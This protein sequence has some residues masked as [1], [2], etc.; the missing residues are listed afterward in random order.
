MRLVPLEAMASGATGG[1]PG[2]GWAEYGTRRK[3]L[4]VPARF[5]WR[6][7]ADALA[8]IIIGLE[9]HAPDLMKMARRGDSRRCALQQRG[10]R[11]ALG[12][13]MASE[14]VISIE[15]IVAREK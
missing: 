5:I 1:F 10:T 4:L 8:R 3:R 15:K 14:K 2:Y 6:K 11:V 13:S 9:R 7:P 12:A